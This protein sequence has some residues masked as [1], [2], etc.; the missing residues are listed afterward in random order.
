MEGEEEILARFDRAA[1]AEKAWTGKGNWR[2]V[3]LAGGTTQL[4]RVIGLSIAGVVVAGLQARLVCR[5]E[6]PE[7]DLYAHLEMHIPEVSCYGHFQRVSWRP[8]R[9]HTNSANAPSH[10]RLRT[11][12]NLSRSIDTWAYKDCGR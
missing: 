5:A 6:L 12:A 10:L 3:E 7:M 11:D 9:P 1:A 2:S 8:L 4:T